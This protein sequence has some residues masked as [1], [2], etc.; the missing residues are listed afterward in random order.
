LKPVAGKIHPR[1]L[2]DR[3]SIEIYAA[4]GLI[5]FPNSVIPDEHNKSCFVLGKGGKWTVKNIQITKL[6]HPGAD[7]I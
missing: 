2:L 6:I 7:R 1:V 5:Y 4:G 3:V